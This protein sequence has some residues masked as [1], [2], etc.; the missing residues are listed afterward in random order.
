MQNLLAKIRIHA[1][2]CKLPELLY[3]Q[4]LVNK[5]DCTMEILRCKVSVA[6][7]TVEF[8]ALAL[9]I[10]SQKIQIVYTPSQCL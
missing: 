7:F 8:A 9:C 10:I 3:G 1:A 4:P 2:V 5:Q 6:I